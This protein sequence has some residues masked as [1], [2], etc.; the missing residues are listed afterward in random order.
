MPTIIL[1]VA[2]MLLTMTAL[3]AGVHDCGSESET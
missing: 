3:A 1:A 2:A